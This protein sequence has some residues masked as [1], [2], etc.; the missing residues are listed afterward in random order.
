MLFGYPSSDQIASKP[1]NELVFPRAS[2][3]LAY[4]E[5]HLGSVRVLSVVSENRIKTEINDDIWPLEKPEEKPKPKLADGE[6]PPA[7]EIPEEE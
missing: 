3:E 6:E 1:T 5:K 4:I 2:D 7:E